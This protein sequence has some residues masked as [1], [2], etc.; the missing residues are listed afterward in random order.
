MKRIVSYALV[1]HGEEVCIN[2]DH[3]SY[4]Y[5]D[6]HNENNTFI[7]MSNGLILTVLAKAVDVRCSVGFV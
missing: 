1:P 7:V 3:I 4:I 5:E 6:R 2:A